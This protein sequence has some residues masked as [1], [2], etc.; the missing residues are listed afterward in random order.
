[1][2]NILENQLFTAAKTIE[3][4]LDQQLDR[5][6]NLDSDDLKVLREQRLREMKDLNNKK[7][8]WLRNVGDHLLQHS[9]IEDTS[10]LFSK[11]YMTKWYST[12]DF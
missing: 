10:R 4:Q 2:A 12:C 11:W 5:L 9:I 1:M 7:Q 3:Q 8:E 6:D